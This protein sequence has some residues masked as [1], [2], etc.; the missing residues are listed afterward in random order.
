MSK[1]G[2]NKLNAAFDQAGQFRRYLKSSV[3]FRFMPLHPWDAKRYGHPIGKAPK[4]GKWTR[5]NYD[6]AEVLND[7]LLGDNLG[8]RLTADILVIDIDPR[9]E[10]DFNFASLAADIGINASEYPTVIT[11]SGGRHIYMSKPAD[12]RVRD[13]LEKYP[14]VEFK[15]FGRQVVAAGSRHPNGSY[16][17]FSKKHPRIE[18]GLPD[19]PPALLQAIQRPDNFAATGGGVINSYEVATVLKR[20]DPDDFA[21]QDKWFK[22][23]CA[24][25]HASAGDARTEFIDWSIK[26][27]GYGD[28]EDDIGARWDSLDP[29]KPGAITVA[30]LNRFLR[31]HGAADAQIRPDAKGLSVD[32]FGDDLEGDDMA[33]DLAKFGFE[34]DDDDDWLNPGI[35]KTVKK[36]EKLANEKPVKIGPDIE[37]ALGDDMGDDDA[38]FMPVENDPY[39]TAR[40]FVRIHHPTLVRHKG[41]WLE[42]NGSHYTVI[43]DETIKSQLYKFCGIG[44]NPN[45]TSV[46]H[47]EDAL[48]AVTHRPEGAFDPPCWLDGVGPTIKGKTFKASEVLALK[49]SLLHLPTGTVIPATADFFTRNALTYSYDPDAP[50]PKAWRRFMLQT[51]KRSRKSIGVLQEIFGYMLLSDNRYQKAFL[52]DGPPRGGKGTSLN[53][54]Q[55]LIG[56]HNCCNPA[57]GGLGK[58][59]ILDSM[60]GKQLA[61]VSDMQINNRTN[62]SDVVGNILRISGNDGVTF[63]RKFKSAWSGKLRVRFFILT[64]SAAELPRPVRRDHQ[65]LC[66]PAKLREQPWQRRH[67]VGRQAINRTAGHPAMGDPRLASAARTRQ[68]PAIARRREDVAPDGRTV[69]AG[70]GVYPR[71]LHLRTRRGDVQGIALWRMVRLRRRARPGIASHARRRRW[72]VR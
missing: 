47:V 22:L 36:L 66:R 67:H 19:A 45:K 29:T 71:T 31:E 7:A 5:L 55:K 53:I 65:P 56:E 46:G 38:M 69:R 1:Q 68:I 57:M 49:D 13:T 28:Y 21:D 30:T 64:N 72:P 52:W 33:D 34:S 25:H 14:G 16:Y 12:M 50:K 39:G 61:I 10:G 17:R 43:E 8:I 48:R 51:F 32:A 62:L 20:L 11:G 35:A 42:Y 41:D 54:L 70:Q 3:P 24:V 15:S 59:A 60:V 40:A 9:N 18:D 58:D 23:L 63:D 26:G 27:D 44:F 6:N 37:D 4:H 2:T